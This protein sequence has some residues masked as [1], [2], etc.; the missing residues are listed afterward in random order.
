M[1]LII[2]RT[3]PIC[4]RKVTYVLHNFHKNGDKIH[5]TTS[6]FGNTTI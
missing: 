1:V 4:S 3:F 5:D 2:L 6:F